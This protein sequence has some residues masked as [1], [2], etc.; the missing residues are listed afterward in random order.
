MSMEL[1][2]Q[3]RFLCSSVFNTNVYVALD[4]IW[5]SLSQSLTGH[6]GGKDSRIKWVNDNR[7]ITTGYDTVCQLQIGRAHV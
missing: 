7:F 1:W 3:Y 5:L 4:L 6:T 2:V